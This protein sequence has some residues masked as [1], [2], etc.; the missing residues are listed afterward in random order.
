MGKKTK[1][2]QSQP[3]DIRSFPI[4]RQ[5]SFNHNLNTFLRMLQEK[6]TGLT[7]REF[8]MEVHSFVTRY[9]QQTKKKDPSIGT[10]RH[11]IKICKHCD[12]WSRNSPMLQCTRC[13]DYYH[14]HCL[15]HSKTAFENSGL[16]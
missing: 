7:S 9:K 3:E 1:K 6:H 12:G 16:C 14:E 8:I 5:K 4:S 13:E 2:T 15:G 11:K 10:A